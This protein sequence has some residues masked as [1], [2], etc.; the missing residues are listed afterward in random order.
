MLPNQDLFMFN[1]IIPTSDLETIATGPSPATLPSHIS[2]ENNA[3]LAKTARGEEAGSEVAGD[4]GS[5]LMNVDDAAILPW[6]A[7]PIR[8][9]EGAAHLPTPQR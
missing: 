7:S 2:K 1:P 9:M 4:P 6:T 8:R 3:A 5:D